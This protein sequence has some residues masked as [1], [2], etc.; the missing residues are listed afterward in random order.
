MLILNAVTSL[1]SVNIDVSYSNILHIEF[2][3]SRGWFISIKKKSD[4]ET[5]PMNIVTLAHL[6]QH[7]IDSLS[8]SFS[9]TTA[10]NFKHL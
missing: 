10:S 3:P 7:A 2:N 6:E 8:F 1:V 9:I 5:E 4:P